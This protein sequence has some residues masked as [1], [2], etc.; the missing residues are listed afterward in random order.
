MST[1]W[2]PPHERVTATALGSSIGVFGVA[3]SFVIGPYLVS[4]ASRPDNSTVPPINTTSPIVSTT[5]SDIMSFPGLF[6][7]ENVTSA[8]I[9]RERTDIMAYMYYSCAWS[10]F[11]TV[12]VIIYFPSKPP[13]PPSS[14]A[15]TKRDQYWEGL[16]SLRKKGSFLA[17]SV[18]FGV[19]SG[20]LGNWASVLNTNLST[21]D[22]SETTVGW[23]GFYATVAECIVS[24]GMG[25]FSSCHVRQIKL[26][27][28]TL[29]VLGAGCFVLF[30]LVLKGIVPFYIPL[31]YM[32]VI[33]GNGFLNGAGPLM[34]ELAAE[35]A[36]PT[37]EAAAN[38]FLTYLN[39]LGGFIFLAVFF[40][41]DIGTMWMNW[42]LI[43]STCLCV[44]LL[45][46]LKTKFNRLEIDEGFSNIEQEVT[47]PES[48]I[49]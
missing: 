2:F 14:S 16:W 22:V 4:E 33:G 48:T 28:L 30:L 43:V 42:F 8:R 34:F 19:S 26:F 18:I 23:I 39:M 35:L 20:T 37:G 5:E 44:P 13:K 11:V 6:E 25:W 17:V 32:T 21:V 31:I 29:Y 12:L 7:S 1:E 41:P 47:V 46:V 27:I 40:I 45:G 24:A 38:G 10:W 36:Y 9:H 49:P 15:A 3:I